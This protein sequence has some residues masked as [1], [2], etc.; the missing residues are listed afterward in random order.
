MSR[1]TDGKY[2]QGFSG[3]PNRRP[4][5]TSTAPSLDEWQ[6]GYLRLLAEKHSVPVNGK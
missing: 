3:N 1:E 5:E 4:I 2:K 6:K